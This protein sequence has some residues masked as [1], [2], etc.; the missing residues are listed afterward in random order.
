M[1]VSGRNYLQISPWNDR[2]G[3]TNKTKRETN[4]YWVT[5]AET[6]AKASKY[7]G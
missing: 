5:N 4:L 3:S 6:H 1:D 2:I 7:G